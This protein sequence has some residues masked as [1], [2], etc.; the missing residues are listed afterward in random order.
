[1]AL[2]LGS[3]IK[4]EGKLPNFVRDSFKT[5]A[6]MKGFPDLKIDSGHIS[7][8]E[9]DRNTYKYDT[10]NSVDVVTG[11]W[12]LFGGGINY[13]EVPKLTE[14]YMVTSNPSLTNEEVY[15]IKIGATVHKVI[16]DSTIKWQDG[17]SPVS[18]ANSVIVVSVLNNLAV[19][20][21]FK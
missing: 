14:D 1:M 17:K 19:W 15:Y 3:N 16:G 4:Y 13:H 21:I 18:E 5:L 7:F 11:K 8:C 9:E 10:N 12:R 2:Q 6:E 20:G